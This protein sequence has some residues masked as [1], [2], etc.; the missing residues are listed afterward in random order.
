MTSP[1]PYTTNQLKAQVSLAHT[2]LES[3]VFNQNSLKGAPWQP[4]F[5]ALITVVDDLLTQ[6]QQAG[7]R[8][9]FYEGVGVNGKLQD[10]TSLVSWLRNCLPGP[11][12]EVAAQLA[13]VRLNRYFDQGTGYFENGSFFTGE[14][15]HELAFFLDDQ[16]I[17]L[18]HHLGRAVDEAEQYWL[19]RK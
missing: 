7:K 13:H 19:S 6:T 17:Y 5:A 3:P 10:I 16:R 15:A 14:Y 2:L 12:P 1:E 11:S 18:K 8:I 9:D 4:V